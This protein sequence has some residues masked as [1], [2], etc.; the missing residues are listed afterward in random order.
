MLMLIGKIAAIFIFF[1]LII[2]NSINSK[3]Q[4]FII[5]IA[6]ILAV[7]LSWLEMMIRKKFIKCRFTDKRTIAVRNVSEE[8]S[9]EIKNSYFLPFTGGK[10]SLKAQLIATG[11]AREMEI[12]LFCPQKSTYKYALSLPVAHCGIWNV[13]CVKAYY[14]DFFRI[15]KRKITPFKACYVV[16][17]PETGYS[18]KNS[19]NVLERLFG[20]NEINVNS[21]GNNSSEVSDLR[22]YQPGDKLNRIHWKMSLK[23]NTL[24]TKEW[25]EEISRKVKIYFGFTSDKN[26]FLD[27]RDKAFNVLYSLGAWLSDND[28]R[29]EIIFDDGKELGRFFISSV[30]EL[31]N[32]VEVMLGNRF[33]S[34]NKKLLDSYNMDKTNVQLDTFYVSDKGIDGAEYGK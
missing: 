2:Y 33:C 12:D 29:Y 10:I 19:W 23:T 18:L 6:F 5:L 22:N 13:S 9:L 7:F 3:F 28:F 30:Q 26:T 16:V 4:P 8:F 20:E 34:E 27:V 25:A 32:A 15:F 17:M 21:K 11:E 1:I 24:M 14:Y 31:S